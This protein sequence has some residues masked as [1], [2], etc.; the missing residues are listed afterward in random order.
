MGG[1]HESEP[2]GKQNVSKKLMDCG[3]K[4]DIH[5]SYQPDALI[6]PIPSAR[7]KAGASPPGVAR[8]AGL[9]YTR[10]IPSLAPPGF[11]GF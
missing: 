1:G 9:P 6:Y 8:G 3:Q 7:L 11:V 2:T 5:C 4:Y 10:Q